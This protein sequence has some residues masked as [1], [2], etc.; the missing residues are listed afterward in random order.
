MRN[1]MTT[2]VFQNQVCVDYTSALGLDKRVDLLRTLPDFCG[3][4][5]VL[6]G[7]GADLRRI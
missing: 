4:R 6:V 7:E 5:V 3:A 2:N 1:G